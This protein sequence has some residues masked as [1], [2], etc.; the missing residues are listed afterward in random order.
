MIS[1]AVAPAS[2]SNRP[3]VLLRPCGWQRKSMMPAALIASRTHPL[4]PSTFGSRTVCLWP[5]IAVCLAGVSAPYYP[6]STASTAE[7]VQHT[8]TAST[9]EAS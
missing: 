9:P 1:R 8:I 3:N 2:A 7:D 4:N 6:R 5:R